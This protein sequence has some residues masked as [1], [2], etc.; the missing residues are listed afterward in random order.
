MDLD[1]FALSAQSSGAPAQ[2]IADKT[3]SE[4]ATDDANGAVQVACCILAAAPSLLKVL[5][6]LRRK[7]L[8]KR[9]V[10]WPLM[11]HM[12]LYRLSVE[13]RLLHLFTQGFGAPAQETADE[14]S[15]E[16]AT[17][18]ANDAVQVVYRI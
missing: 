9:E 1:C 16:M 12:I 7:Q 18:G 17:D 5:A 6:R 10:R 15:N 2:E 14:T 13:F 11:A 8:T 3:R 4:M